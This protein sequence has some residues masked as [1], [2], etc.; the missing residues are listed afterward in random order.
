MGTPDVSS[1]VTQFLFKLLFGGPVRPVLRPNWNWKFSFKI[2]TIKP[3]TIIRRK[4][5]EQ[6]KEAFTRATRGLA[7]E[8]LDDLDI[9]ECTSADVEKLGK[10]MVDLSKEYMT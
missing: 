3:D 5:N 7:H 8:V 2:E 1:Q 9:P 10:K 4:T 6:Q